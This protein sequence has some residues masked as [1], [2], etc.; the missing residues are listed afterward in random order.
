[1]IN[2]LNMQVIITSVNILNCKKHCSYVLL[3]VIRNHRLHLLSDIIHVDI[4][5]SML[6]I[7]S[8]KCDDL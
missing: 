3:R 1:M 5:G 6:F 8:M 4:L 7:N 2:K